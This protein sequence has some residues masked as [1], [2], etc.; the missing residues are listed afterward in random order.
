MKQ[1]GYFMVYCGLGLMAVM[2]YYTAYVL[3]GF[4]RYELTILDIVV[5]II[6]AVPVLLL[7]VGW[8]LVQKRKPE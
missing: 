5:T 8:L 4:Q 3:I 1:L 6:V 2:F 7:V